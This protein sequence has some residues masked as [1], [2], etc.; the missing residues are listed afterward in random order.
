MEWGRDDNLRRVQQ[1]DT[2]LAQMDCHWP[3]HPN[4]NDDTS[5]EVSVRH[6]QYLC[7]MGRCIGE[8]RP[9]AACSSTD[10]SIV[11]GI[12]DNIACIDSGRSSTRNEYNIIEGRHGPVVTHKSTIPRRN[13]RLQRFIAAKQNQRTRALKSNMT[14]PACEDKKSNACEQDDSLLDVGKGVCK[15]SSPG[16]QVEDYDELDSIPNNSNKTPNDVASLSPL[17]EERKGSG[18]RHSESLHCI[19]SPTSVAELP[20]AQICLE[21]SRHESVPILGEQARNK[22]KYLFVRVESNQNRKGAMKQAGRNICQRQTNK[23]TWWDDQANKHRRNNLKSDAS[24]DASNDLGCF[25]CIDQIQELSFGRITQ[26]ACAEHNSPNEVLGRNRSESQKSMAAYDLLPNYKAIQE[27]WGN[28][29]RSLF[30][31]DDRETRKTSDVSS[32]R[33]VDLSVKLN[34]DCFTLDDVTA[35]ESRASTSAKESDSLCDSEATPHTNNTS[36]CGD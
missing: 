6:D 26:D 7:T 30:Y 19:E 27:W 10:D 9:S 23:L 32:S 20:S 29:T 31:A 34:L 3:V 25:C 13:N 12:P 24:N 18:E 36:W 4:D 33:E 8:N 35:D 17:G 22:Q 11:E 2:F 1:F 21:T 5:I 14:L 16:N 28:T 15:F